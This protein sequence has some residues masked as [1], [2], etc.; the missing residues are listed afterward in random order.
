MKP[1]QEQILSDLKK[2][3]NK[4]KA[5]FFP[6]F[7]KTGPGEYGEGD[8]FLGV[9]VPVQR[10][11]AK[12]YYKEIDIP[13][14]TS[15]ITSPFHEVRLTTLFILVFKFESKDI[16]E[17]K[18]KEILDFYLKH[19]NS[20]NNWDL[21]D[22]SAD[23][24]LGAFLFQRPR[25]VLD[26]FHKSKD[27]WK[28]RISILSTF[29]FI[30][31]NDFNDTLRYCESYLYHKHDLIHKATGWMLREIGNRDKKILINFLQSHAAKMPRTMLRYAIEKLPES[32][33]KFW[34]SVK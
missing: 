30:R 32:E 3:G 34:L 29:Y 24:I 9:T 7:F 26:K 21:V 17:K 27:L 13:S 6:K 28:N 22:S 19:T 2:E 11:I 1:I 16:T 8:I 31:K 12:K 18:Q 10:K 14:L 20:I 4:E 23:K 25:D 33:R 15:L 5:D